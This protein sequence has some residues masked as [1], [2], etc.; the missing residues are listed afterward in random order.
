MPMPSNLSEKCELVS[1]CLLFISICSEI[2][3]N[4]AVNDE[5]SL[6]LAGSSVRAGIEVLTKV[7]A[8]LRC[9]AFSL[10]VSKADVAKY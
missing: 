5:Q 1:F 9:L 2:A 7:S 4:V 8:V 3:H 10:Q 6:Q